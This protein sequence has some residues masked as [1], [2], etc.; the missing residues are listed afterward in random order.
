MK[1]VVAI[2]LYGRMKTFVEDALFRAFLS[3]Y[4]N[5]GRAPLVRWRNDDA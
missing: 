1:V 2:K 4:D 5:N 3:V